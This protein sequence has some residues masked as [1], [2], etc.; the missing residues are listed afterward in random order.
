MEEGETLLIFEVLA[1]VHVVKSVRALIFC[2]ACKYI[3]L[4][5]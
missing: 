5:L 2:W 3:F 1:L 4:I